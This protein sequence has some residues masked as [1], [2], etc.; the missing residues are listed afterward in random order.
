MLVLESMVLPFVI[1]IVI[2][3]NGIN[4]FAMEAGAKIGKILRFCFRITITE[5]IPIV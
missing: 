5:T 4:M 3:P 2:T 1:T